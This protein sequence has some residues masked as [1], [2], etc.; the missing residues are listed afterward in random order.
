MLI[1]L[2]RPGLVLVVA[3]GVLLSFW[4]STLFGHTI[5]AAVA[6]GL[7]VIALMVTFSVV[8]RLAEFSGL[9]GHVLTAIM[10]RYHLPPSYF[11]LAARGVPG[12]AAAWVGVGLV[13][14]LVLWQSLGAFKRTQLDRR[15]VRRYVAALLTAAGA[16]AFAF[17]LSRAALDQLGSAPV[18]ELR[19]AMQAL[20]A[21]NT[22]STLQVPVAIAQAQLEGTLLLSSA[23]KR[24]LSGSEVAVQSCS[25]RTCLALVTF[26][27][28]RG[29]PFVYNRLQTAR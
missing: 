3:G 18:R 17:G 7:I 4:A 23:T 16:L 19:A 15:S 5:R 9:G 8:F 11:Y 6:T 29:Y 24:W 13:V 27:G 22:A 2:T 1:P 25:S 21:A 10:V 26:P 28:G 12:T 20:T 14:A